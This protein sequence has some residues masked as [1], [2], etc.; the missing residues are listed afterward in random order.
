MSRLSLTPQEVNSLFPVCGVSVYKGGL[1]IHRSVNMEFF[2]AKKLHVRG[3][4]E[5]LSKRSLSRLALLVSSSSIVFRSLLTLTYGQNFPVT[6][7]ECK[8]HLNKMLTYMKRCFGDFDYFWV[9]EFQSR[10][11]P[12]FHIGLSIPVSDVCQR[13]TLAEIWSGIVEE[14]NWP[15]TVVKPPYGKGNAAFGLNTRDAVLMQHRR[16]KT[17]ENIRKQD[18]AKRYVIKYATKLKQKTVP[19]WFKQTGRFW[20][21]SRSVKAEAITEL[22]GSEAAIREMIAWLGRD[23]KGFE[24]LPRIVFHS[25]NLPP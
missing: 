14:G 18:G 8:F 2:R 7:K 5:S 23:L 1:V 12:H 24:V 22:P 4:V 3:N 15:Y 25:G 16:K 11:S 17:W 21:T 13:E 20:G 10:G 9:M 6:G 19:K